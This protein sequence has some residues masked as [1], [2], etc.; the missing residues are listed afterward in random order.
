MGNRLDHQIGF[1]NV[2]GVS[3]LELPG[4]RHVGRVA[5]RGTAIHPRHDRRDFGIAQ[6]RVILE[7]VD[8]HGPVDVPRRHLARRDLLPDGACP[9][10]HLFVGQEGHRRHRIGTMTRLTGTLQEWRDVLGERHVIG[11]RPGGSLSQWCCA[12]A[13]RVPISDLGVDGPCGN[14]SES[15]RSL[16][17]VTDR[18]KLPKRVRAIASKAE[19]R[20]G[21][22]ARTIS[23]PP[24]PLC[25][26]YR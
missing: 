15:A 20:R 22:S 25:S 5:L 6:R 4:P 1:A 8:A 23:L 3:V 11:N 17:V 24:H 18:G 10:P 7:L 26:R 19:G 12:R 2:P 16:A 9:G 21:G 13:F 14:Q